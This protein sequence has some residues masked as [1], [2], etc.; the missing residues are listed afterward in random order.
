M[1]V[2]TSSSLRRASIKILE[3]MVGVC[4]MFLTSVVDTRK[5][6]LDQRWSVQSTMVQCLKH[7][8][9]YVTRFEGTIRC[10]TWPIPYR[11]WLHVSLPPGKMICK[12]SSE[13]LT[14]LLQVPCRPRLRIPSRQLQCM[15]YQRIWQ[16]SRERP[17][18]PRYVSFIE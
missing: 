10:L 9:P 12:H 5:A 14:S 2:E 4:F 17:R 16:H 1:S 18:Q 11:T 8:S 3:V 15:E 13:T 7:D 6:T